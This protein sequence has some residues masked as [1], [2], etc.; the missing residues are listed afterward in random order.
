MTSISKASG[1]P[2]P[3]VR[4]LTSDTPAGR[5]TEL[6]DLLEIDSPAGTVTES[7]QRWVMNAHVGG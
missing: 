4:K 2:S 5:V 3:E 1:C 7:P 6:P